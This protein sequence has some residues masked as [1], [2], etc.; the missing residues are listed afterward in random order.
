MTLTEKR[1]KIELKNHSN[2]ALPLISVLVA[3]L[4]NQSHMVKGYKVRAEV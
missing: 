2:Y 3:I 4:Y 1:A